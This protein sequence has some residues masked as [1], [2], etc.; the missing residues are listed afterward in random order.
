MVGRHRGKVPMRWFR[1][2]HDLRLSAASA[3][4]LDVRVA[5]DVF[6]SGASGMRSSLTV[7]HRSSLAGSSLTSC[8]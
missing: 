4:T 8:H 7:E 3:T 2:A 5:I 1:L 6:G